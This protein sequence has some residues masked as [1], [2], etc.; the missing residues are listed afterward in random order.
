MVRKLRND[1]SC[2]YLLSFDPA[3]LPEDRR[4]GVQLEITRPK[5]KARTRRQIIVRSAAAGTETE[6]TAAFVAPDLSPAGLPILG[7]VIPTAYG[8]GK[9]TALVQVATPS[10]PLAA[11]RWEFGISDLPG[12]GTNETQGSLSVVRA[13]VPVVFEAELA[14]PPGPHALAVVAQEA[15]AGEIGTKLLSGAWP[16]PD[17]ASLTIGPVA[18]LQPEE[19]LFLRGEKSRSR[20][21]L[22]RTPENPVRTDRPTALVTLVCAGRSA[23][24]GPVRVER[25]LAGGETVSFPDI[26]VQMQDP[27][28]CAQVRDM[29]RAGTMTEGT[30]TYGIRVFEG[31]REAAASEHSFQA[32]GPEPGGAGGE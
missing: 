11:T 17:S 12:G 23:D 14:I 32:V 6:L 8:D 5:V 19:A 28:R 4:L 13:G 9:Y 31:E 25:F 2:I 24:L 18:L 30:F 22:I 1:L 27:D 3:G 26:Q 21:F 29:V 10:S 7:A 16:D 20:G 15:T